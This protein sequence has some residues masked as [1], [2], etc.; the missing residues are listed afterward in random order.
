MPKPQALLPAAIDNLGK[1]GTARKVDDPQTPGLS[2]ELLKTG[3]RR[4]L[5]RRRIPGSDVIVT[6]RGDIFPAVSIA[7]AR[8]WAGTL[9]FQVEA[10]IDPRVAEREAKAH[11]PMT[12]ARAHA[13]YMVAVHEGRA[14]GI[15]RPNKPRTIKDKLYIYQK[16]VAPPLADKL[17][18]E[19]TEEDLVALILAKGKQARIR[20]NRLAAE[21]KVFFGWACS[22]RGLEVGLKEDPSRRLSDLRFPETPRSRKLSLAEI[23][24]FMRAVAL[25]PRPFQRG[26]LLW[27]LTAVRRNELTEGRSTEV[28]Q[29]VWTI[30]ATRSKNGIEHA[31]ALGPWGASLVQSD[32]EWIIPNDRRDGPRIWGWPKSRNR[33]VERM[34]AYAGRPVKRFSPHDC[35]RTVRSNTKRLRVDYETA[36]AMLNHTKK[37]LERTYDAYELEDEKRAWF[38]VWEQ[39]IVRIARQENLIGELAIP[40]EAL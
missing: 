25:E 26:W 32:S 8:G 23:G 6:V 2:V 5:Y 36:E 17:M 19:V 28:E 4:W 31:I 40:A 13:L 33:I 11:V 22:L 14:S 27:L 35:R 7:D 18:A 38:L 20:A 16:D 21:L 9:N 1:S 10:G 34:S 29:G 3:R 24:W 15:D 12:V 30:P 37:G 39:E